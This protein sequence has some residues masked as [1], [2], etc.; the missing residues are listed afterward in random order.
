MRAMLLSAGLGT[1]LRPLTYKVAKSMIPVINR[2]SISYSLNSLKKTG[3][4][5]VVVNLYHQAWQVKEYLGKGERFNIQLFY[6]DEEHLLG[7]AGG[8]KKMEAY[9]KD[10][11]LV[12]SADGITNFDLS[13]ALQFHKQKKALATVILKRV[14]EK[15]K[16]GV[17]QR[18]EENQITRFVEK[19]DWGDVFSNE[20]NT[21]IYIFEPEIFS[22]IPSGEP[23]DFG[24]QVL[25]FLARERKK[26]YGYLMDNYWADIGNLQDYRKIQK[27]ILEGGTG[28]QIPGKQSRK[29][30][31]IG[32]DSEVST[33]AI[34]EP[35]IVIGDNCRI[36]AGVKIG[37]YTTLG[38]RVR[39]KKGA[40]L[41]RCI[42]WN[43]VL[44][45]EKA[46]LDDCILSHFTCIPAGFS[47]SE[48]VVVGEE[49]RSKK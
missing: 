20:V 39:I 23:Y 19:P 5:G 24:H 18:D 29:G 31:W 48:G 49:V 3:T 44:V 6:S 28:I 47:M 42:L 41:E 15:F 35:P 45:G 11:F 22:Y 16:Y 27:D 21:G 43:D 33:S 40:S 1:R 17:V 38:H 32:E 8:L 7:T 36:E 26:V 34:L 14:G 2:P 12:L 13:E 4:R 30:I 46:H 10:T 9:F 37:K 25:P